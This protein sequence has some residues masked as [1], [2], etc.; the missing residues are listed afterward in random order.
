MDILSESYK[1]SG[2]HMKFKCSKGHERNIV[3]SSFKNKVSCAEC[4]G[5]CPIAAGK[6]FIEKIKF[7]GGIVV[8]K[9]IKC[10][11]PVQCICINGHECNAI[12]SH[13]NAG[14]GMCNKCAR[15]SPELAKENFIKNI[16]KL[17]GKVI[18][19]YI[20]CKLK[21]YCKCEND[22]DC[23]PQPT[24]VQQGHGICKICTG[25]DFNTAKQNFIINII[26]LGGHVIGEYKGAHVAVECRC[27][28]NHI[29]NAL[30]NSIQQGRGMCLICANQDPE[31]SKQ[32][33]TMRIEKLGGKVIGIYK[34]SSTPVTC[35]CKNGHICN[36]QPTTI[37]RGSGM[38]KICSKVDSKTS[39]ENFIKNITK[40]NGVVIGNYINNSTPIECKCHNGHICFPRP[41]NIQREEGM[42]KYCKPNYGEELTV[43][44]LTLLGIQFKR[45]VYHPLIKKL[46]FDFNFNFNNVTY[47]IEYDGIQHQKETPH[48][49][50]K[51]DTFL[52]SRQKDLIKNE[53]IK[54]DP[55]SRL[56]RLEHLWVDK[57]RTVEELVDYIVNA[58][59]S[60]NKIVANLNIYTWINDKP[61]EEI[62]NKYVVFNMVKDTANIIPVFNIIKDTANIIP[63]FNIIKDT[64]NIVP[65][66]NIIKDT[67][68]IVPFFNIS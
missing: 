52:F 55:N 68:N 13:V 51:P 46:R 12:P 18:G 45:E 27:K 48:F 29:W 17:G 32:N 15:R 43:K 50:R 6:N 47:Y 23:Y 42:C 49:H 10:S 39:E 53:V 2:T 19:E 11:K 14:K 40:L 4:K 36:P 30:P 58:V 41:A 1:N 59:N 56:I 28:F 61:I 16:E 7:L 62:Y 20:N 57:K 65:V 44:A 63:V 67:G 26:K 35:L 25:K 21:V 66:F 24:Q 37:Q 5:V 31:T 22:H 8:G 60:G 34:K 64:G 38:C 54:N 9:Y 3:P 33:F